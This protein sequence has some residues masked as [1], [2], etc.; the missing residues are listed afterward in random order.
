MG[1]LACDNRAGYV[2]WACNDTSPA[3]LAA[4]SRPAD[5]ILVGEATQDPNG[6]KGEGLMPN[7][8]WQS[9]WSGQIEGMAVAGPD[10]DGGSNWEYNDGAWKPRYRHNGTSNMVFADGHAKAMVKGRF[11]L[12]RNFLFG[13]MK[14]N[15]TGR[16]GDFYFQAGQPCAGYQP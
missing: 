12:C 3:T 8:D 14:E 16:T 5:L 13:G 1:M 2:H 4:V 11:N 9:G 10:R 6:G 7:F 15:W